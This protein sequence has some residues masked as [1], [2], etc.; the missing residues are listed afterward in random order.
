MHLLRSFVSLLLLCG[1]TAL[2]VAESSQPD[3]MAER[4][5]GVVTTKWGK[6]PAVYAR[7]TLHQQ[8]PAIPPEVRDQLA[9]DAKIV[10]SALVGDKGQVEDTNLDQSSG[11]QKLDA[12]VLVAL[13]KWRFAPTPDGARFVAVQVFDISVAP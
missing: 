11:N 2:A 12:A 13:S 9:F 3:A 5:L 8:A 7:K 1:L 4:S 6:L 10:V